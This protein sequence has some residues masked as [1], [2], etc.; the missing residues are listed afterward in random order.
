MSSSIYSIYKSSCIVTGKCYI[1]FDS[2]WP[3]RKIIH[4]SN[5]P[6][7]K[8]KFYNVIRKYGLDNFYWEV[9]YQSKERE[10]T[11]KVMENYFINEYDSFS[12][13][14]NTTL[15]GEGVFGLSRTQS[16]EEKLKRSLSLKGNK[17]GCGNKGKILSEERKISL[18]KPRSNP[19][20]P[21]TQE[22]KDNISKSHKGRITKR[23]TCP[24]CNKIG[25]ISQMKQW[26]FDRCKYKQ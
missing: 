3:R 15:G 20:K 21:L 18:R 7:L 16:K 1:G 12:R 6:K 5:Y 19:V 17:N 11:L 10:H 8:F 24:Y 9:L 2:K 23:I 4:K 13:G 22:H 14:Y 25:G 26:H